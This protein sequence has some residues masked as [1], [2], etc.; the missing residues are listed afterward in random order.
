MISRWSVFVLT[1]LL[2]FACEKAADRE[3]AVVQSI[4]QTGKL[5]TVEY[6]LS[7]VIRAADNKTWYKIGERRILISA[8]ATV[9]AGVDLQNITAED[10]SISG[11]EIRLRLPPPQLFSVSLPPEGIQV[12]YENTSLFRQRFT[13][14]EREALLRQAERQIRSLTDS[15]DI[16]KTAQINAETFLRNLLQ[17]GGYKNVTITFDQ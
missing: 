1:S 13:A 12:L 9:T 10:V 5:V 3:G 15:L 6:S 7:K 8:R 17:Q 11:E 14:A 2:L 16:L 4:Q